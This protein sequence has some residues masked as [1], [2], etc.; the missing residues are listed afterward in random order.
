MT[1]TI[2]LFV[3]GWGSSRL[4][5]ASVDSCELDLRLLW[6]SALL[7]L[8]CCCPQSLFLHRLGWDVAI[9]CQV[10]GPF[11]HPDIGHDKRTTPVK[12]W[13]EHTEEFCGSNL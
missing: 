2:A 5:N 9:W 10:S 1:H 12:A 6:E 11:S 7:T 13:F 4:H 8:P 3:R